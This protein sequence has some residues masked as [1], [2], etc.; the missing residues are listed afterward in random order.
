MQIFLLNIKYNIILIWIWIFLLYI[1]QPIN[2][3]KVTADEWR[4]VVRNEERIYF[5]VSFNDAGK[6]IIPVLCHNI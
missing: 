3:H 6:N 4:T 2:S 1:N 5:S